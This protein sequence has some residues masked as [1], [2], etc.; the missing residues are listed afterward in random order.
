MPVDKGL[1]FGQIHTERL[2]GGNKGFQPLN[3]RSKLAQCC[4]GLGRG[5]PQLLPLQGPDFRDLPLDHIFLHKRSFS[6]QSLREISCFSIFLRIDAE[7]PCHKI[8]AG[9]PVEVWVV[10]SSPDLSI[11]ENE[12][13]FHLPVFQVDSWPC[14]NDE[15]TIM[16]RPRVKPCVRPRTFSSNTSSALD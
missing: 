6:L 16:R 1:I 2:V 5:F 3:V 7:W 15:L 4:V 14:C 8:S 10:T 13:Q 12:I 9:S 11:I